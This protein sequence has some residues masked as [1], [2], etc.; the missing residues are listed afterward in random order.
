MSMINPCPF[1]SHDDVQVAEPA[2]GRYAIDCPECE[3]VGPIKDDALDAI[4]AWNSASTSS[5]FVMSNQDLDKAIETAAKWTAFEFHARN[6]IEAMLDHL[7][8]LLAIQKARAAMM[9]ID[10]HNARI[11]APL[12]SGRLE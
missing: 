6:R 7:K 11:E 8:D 2:T 3:C 1:C 12:T 5:A 9:Q 4:R 10:A